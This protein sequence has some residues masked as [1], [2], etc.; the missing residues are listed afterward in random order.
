LCN[1]PLFERRGDLDVGQF[2]DPLE[3]GFGFAFVDPAFSLPNL[4]FV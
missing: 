4:A 1:Q 2:E 3:G